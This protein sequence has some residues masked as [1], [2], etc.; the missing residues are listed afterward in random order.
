[1]ATAE[2]VIR[3]AKKWIGY[4]SADDPEQGSVFGR[5]YAKLTNSPYFGTNGVPYCM[6]GVSYV[7]YHVGVQCL[8]LPTAGCTSGMLRPARSAG[9]LLKPSELKRGDPILFNWT[10]KGYYADEADHVGIVLYWNSSTN[11][12][13]WEA[14]VSGGVYE[15][16]RDIKRVVGGVRPQYTKPIFEDVTES[17]PHYADI[18]W[19]KEHGITTGFADGTFRPSADTARGDMAAFLHRLKGTPIFKDVTIKTAHAEDI[20]WLAVNGISTGYQDGTFRPSSSVRRCDMAA[21]L[22]RLVNGVTFAYEPTQEDIERFSDVDWQTPHCREIWWLAHEGITTGYDDGTFRPA[23][24]L[25]RCD[26]AAFLYRV[27]GLAGV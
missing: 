5:W 11:V 25:K 24:T 4:R 13:T 3:E 6:M 2:D 15:C 7:F 8:G 17:T 12:H 14:N 21:F 27:N 18:K 22:C 20:W 1:M 19:M 16:D 23:S 26:A 10:G 9:K